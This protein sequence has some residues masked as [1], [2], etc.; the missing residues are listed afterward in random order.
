MQCF[1]QESWP[2]SSWRCLTLHQT[3][4]KPEPIID[5]VSS[6]YLILAGHEIDTFTN[7]TRKQ[8]I[9]IGI[10]INCI[11]ISH[12]LAFTLRRIIWVILSLSRGLVA[13]KSWYWPKDGLQESSKSS[14]LYHEQQGGSYTLHSLFLDFP[15]C[16]DGYLSCGD[17]FITTLREIEGTI[18]GEGWSGCIT[19]SIFFVSLLY[20]AD[21]CDPTGEVKNHRYYIWLINFNFWVNDA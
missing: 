19:F 16:S 15:Q 21:T 7:T 12:Y 14:R 2:G 17:D 13:I 11:Y 20:S 3:Q 6:V 4:P 18:N 9:F 10:G 8:S 5:T 1:K